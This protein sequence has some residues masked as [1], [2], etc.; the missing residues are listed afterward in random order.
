MK[1]WLERIKH[2]TKSA[3]HHLKLGLYDYDD[4]DDDEPDDDGFG[5][6]W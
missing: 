5:T 4:E 6:H 2:K 3:C 1:E